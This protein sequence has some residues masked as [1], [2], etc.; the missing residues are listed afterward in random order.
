MWPPLKDGRGL[1]PRLRSN[2]CPSPKSTTL[3]LPKGRIRSE[4]MHV[5]RMTLIW[6]SCAGGWRF[7][8]ILKMLRLLLPSLSRPDWNRQS[9]AARLYKGKTGVSRKEF[10]IR[11]NPMWLLSVQHPF[12]VLHA[13][14]S[15]RPF[16]SE[17]EHPF[18]WENEQ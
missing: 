12:V 18:S 10:K 11:F 8:A 14:R 15:W 16:E 5:S 7:S 3:G 6:S 4:T 2:P 17:Q 9:L 1:A 13:S